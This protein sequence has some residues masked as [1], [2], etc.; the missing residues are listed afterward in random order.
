M[1]P[2]F[3]EEIETQ[4]GYLS[5]VTQIVE[6]G[7]IPTYLTPKLNAVNHCIS[8]INLFIQKYVQCVLCAC[9]MLGNM[10]TIL[11]ITN[12]YPKGVQSGEGNRHLSRQ[13]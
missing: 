2:I 6:L 9:T 7:W 4:K 1:I 8:F 11:K 3:E 13:W 5:K 12:F 10:D